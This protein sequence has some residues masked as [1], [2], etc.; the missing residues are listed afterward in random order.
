MRAV[1]L[2]MLAFACQLLPA[3]EKLLPVFH[4]NHLST[5]SGLPTDEIPSNVVRDA[6]GFV[7]VGTKDG[8]VRFDGHSCEV[9]RNNRPEPGKLSS[10]H[11]MALHADRRGFLWFGTI[12]TARPATEAGP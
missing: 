5:A 6:Q 2:L 8:L 4:F 11:I 9:Y 3:Q 7:W 1:P 12:S 10:S